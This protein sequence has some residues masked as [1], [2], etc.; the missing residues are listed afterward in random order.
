VTVQCPRCGTQYRVTDA[1]LSESRPVF[2]CTR[3]NHVFA[4]TERSATRGATRP[5]G[6]SR[7]L[8]L[9]F[10][11]PTRGSAS[12][13]ASLHGPADEEF[14]DL[15]EEGLPDDEQQD[16][17]LGEDPDDEDGEEEDAA[18]RARPNAAASRRRP[19]A[20]PAFVADLPRG[21]AGT[22]RRSEPPHGAAAAR[23]RSRKATPTAPD[24]DDDPIDFDDERDG[25]DGEGPVLISHPDR[26]RRAPIHPRGR[27]ATPGGGRSPLKPITIGVAA[28]VGACLLLTLVLARRPDLAFAQLGS[29]PLLGKLLGDDHL[30]VWR[31]QIN[32]VESTMDHIKGDRP[33]LV[34]S[35]QVVNTSGQTLRLIEV[36]GLL[37]A[38]GVERRRQ[39]VY[40]AN[41]FRK[42]IR[43]LSPSEVEMLL[44][45]EPNRR[46]AVRPGESAS[47]LIVFP[48]P[49]ANATEVTCRIV[50]AQPA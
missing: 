23:S 19:V 14:D 25:D 16:E 45:L 2:K 10:D 22:A 41:Q 42:T 3:C 43:D 44:R 32:G 29:V 46:F 11:P 40:A 37:L 49:P 17:S 38:D 50:D 4:R 15:H 5:R 30:L 20:E 1:R 36:E 8:D 13:P 12:G 18:T 34:V 48:D 28:V 33:A 27:R 7:N 9:P 26:S 6:E 47:F 31:L 24:P 39:M 35:G 21:D